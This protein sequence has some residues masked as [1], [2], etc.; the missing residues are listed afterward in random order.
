MTSSGSYTDTPVQRRGLKWAARV[1][2]GFALVLVA[3]VVAALFWV[4][5]HGL[6]APDWLHARLEEKLSEI[7]PGLDVGV[8]EVH[9]SISEGW[10]PDLT[11]RNLALIPPA[12]GDPITFDTVTG[13]FDPRA[14]FDGVLRP[15]KLLVRGARIHIDRAADGVFSIAL[16]PIDLAA[17]P[18]RARSIWHSMDLVSDI[19]RR[20]AFSALR[21][22]QG[23]ALLIRYEDRVSGRAWTVDSGLIDLT[24]D[25][26]DLRLHGDF[27]LLGGH[28]YA[29]AVQTTVTGRL[30]SHEASLSLRVTDM[31]ARDIATQ[32]A[33]LAWLSV[34]DAPISGAF[35]VTTT[36]DGQVGPLNGT[37]QIGEGAIAPDATGDPVPF[38]AARTYFEYIPDRRRLRFDEVSVQS[39]WGD[40][41]AEGRI[42]LGEISGGVPASMIGQFRIAQMRLNPGGQ[43]A[44]PILLEGASADLRMTLDP[45]HIDIGGIRVRDGEADLNLSGWVAGRPEGWDV[46][47]SGRMNRLDRDGLLHYWPPAAIGRTRDWVA[48]NVTTAQAK[49][50]QL[51]LRLRPGQKP[52][53]MLGLEFENLAATFMKTMPPVTGASGRIEMRDNRFVIEAD[54]GEVR[55]PDDGGALDIS[56]TSFAYLDTR[57]KKGPARIRLSASGALPDMLAL[58]DRPPLNAMSKAG[59]T[60]DLAKG[61]IDARATLDLPLRKGVKLEEVQAS[62]EA[63]LHEIESDRIAP[64]KTLT[65]DKLTLSGTQSDLSISGEARLN[66]IPAGGT[67]RAAL[68]PGGDAALDGWVT[69]SEAANSALSLGLEPGMLSGAGRGQMRIDFTKGEAPRFN[70]TSD[71][72][73]LGL[74]IPALNWS[75]GQASRGK[76]EVTGAM[77]TP[78]RID[79]LSLDLPGLSAEGKLVLNPGGGLQEARFDRVRVGDWLDA[80]VLLTGRG[81]GRSPAIAITGGSVDLRKADL[82]GGGSGQQRAAGGGAPV[83]LTLDRLQVTDSIALRGFR[84]EFDTAGGLSGRFAASL[85][86]AAPVE[87]TV[88]PRNGG[89]AVRITAPDAGAALSAAGLLD[90]GREGTLDLSLTPAGS[91]GQYDGLLKVQDIWVQDTPTMAS[92]LSALSIVGLL[93][94]LSGRGILFNDIDAN[95]RLT[96]SQVILR[97]GSAVGASMG[98]SMDGVYNLGPKSLNMQGVVSPFYFVNQIGGIFSRNRGEGLIGF[99]YNLRGTAE[100]PNVQ[101]NPISLFTPGIFREIFRRPPPEVN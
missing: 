7:V 65:A 25:G 92:M 91:P 56:G 39:D 17:D 76:V 23:E 84:G 72:N 74:R 46:S 47:L 87:G 31:P 88:V 98:V 32:S 66:G 61:R 54:R 43:F 1:V 38:T 18:D 42:D 29:S 94:Q 97:S 24:R 34:L 77:S 5:E 93:E 12:P 41:V 90:K 75:L 8:G 81:A 36:G 16:V 3:A 62:Y 22:V 37:L 48:E 95:F 28:A 11:L 19:L 40:A 100:K 21:Q 68:G 79:R 67:F 83:K 50:I 13:S 69:V 70:L 64:G 85:N 57:V 60:P 63:D 15:R 45:F 82:G 26:E 73:G 27:P 51:G 9:L 96:P 89:S 59:R 49:D 14:L 44:A 35:R 86:G 99:N 30:G 53:L 4:R 20:P 101:V 2:A 52:D 10:Q 78:P 80:P 58:L 6:T 55:L 71:L 33:G